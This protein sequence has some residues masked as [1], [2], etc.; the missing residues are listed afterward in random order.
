MPRTIELGEKVAKL[1]AFFRREQRMPGYQEMLGLFDYGSKNAVHGL[2]LKL[3]EAGYVAKGEGGKISPTGKL[4]G[5]IRVLGTV[6][7]GFPS[8]A[9]EELADV[10]SLDEF[11]IRKPD[12]TFMLTV[13]GD[14]MIDAGIYPGD[15]VLVERGR[16][17]KSG[18]IVVAQVDGEWTM[19]YYAKDR[20]GIRLNPANKKYKSIRPKQNLNLGGVVRGVVRKYA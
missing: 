11:L 13:N 17:V 12:A 19:K 8:P 2:L 18:D 14:S 7:A 16:P 6:Q 3:A 4:T 5:A 20:T 15:L 9:E 10:L 1:R